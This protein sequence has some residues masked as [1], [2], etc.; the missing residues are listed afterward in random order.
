MILCLATS[1][2]RVW[3]HRL[4]LHANAS[5]L[6]PAKYKRGQEIVHTGIALR[7]LDSESWVLATHFIIQP[8]L[9]EPHNNIVGHNVCS[10][11]LQVCVLF[12]AK[13]DGAQTQL[14]PEIELGS[15]DSKS[16]VLRSHHKS[17]KPRYRT[18]TVINPNQH[19][20]Y[21][22]V[23]NVGGSGQWDH[24]SRPRKC[25]AL[26]NFQR[27]YDLPC[28]VADSFWNIVCRPRPKKIENNSWCHRPFRPYFTGKEK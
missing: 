20:Q 3:K 25:T 21:A 23:I 17:I 14:L 27:P 26:Y 11:Q 4:C 5:V 19:R 7:W 10:F 6:L 12:T 15:L 18:S 28:C 24:I 9:V 2:Q 1:V 22:S 8:Y 16:T 13:S